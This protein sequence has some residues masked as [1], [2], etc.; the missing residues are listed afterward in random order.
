MVNIQRRQ[1]N[2]ASVTGRHFLFDVTQNLEELT[3]SWQT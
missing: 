2:R 3:T 1:N